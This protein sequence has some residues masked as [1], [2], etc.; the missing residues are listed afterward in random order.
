MLNQISSLHGRP[1][2][3]VGA[4]AAV[5][6]VVPL[7]S[8]HSLGFARAPQPDDRSRALRLCEENKF[9]EA[10]PILE[11]LN[12][13]RRC[14]V[15]SAHKDRESRKRD[16]ESSEQQN[17]RLPS[18]LDSCFVVTTDKIHI[19]SLAVLL[20]KFRSKDIETSRY[21]IARL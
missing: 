11:K 6:F 15:Y 14:R 4:V 21:S 3:F 17:K 16:G 8:S 12:S 9:V 1:S 13:D 20:H 7:I 19:P 2:A 10:L 5:F 18:H